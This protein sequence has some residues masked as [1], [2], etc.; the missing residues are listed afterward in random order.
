MH[1]H[2][3]QN[4]GDCELALQ[5]FQRSVD[6][7]LQQQLYAESDVGRGRGTEYMRQQAP[8]QV[9]RSVYVYV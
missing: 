6:I 5:A 2:R 9:G 8:L 3:Y 7:D 1:T 4:M